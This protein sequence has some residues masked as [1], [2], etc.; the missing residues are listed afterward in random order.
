MKDTG[1]KDIKSLIPHREPFLFVDE[2][3]EVMQ[4]YIVGRR[5]YT[6]DDYFFKGHF[7]QYPIVPGVIL[8]ESMAQ[9]GGAGVVA[10]G[11]GKGLIP[12]FATLDKV[13]FR[14]PVLP[15]DDVR[16]EIENIRMSEKIVR[17]AGKAYVEDDL[18][19]E[20]TWLCIL[21]NKEDLQKWSPSP[22]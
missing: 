20:A 5:R 4:E 16:F 10:L 3:L 11:V 12:F 8:T 22:K 2:L 7:P 21:N 18:A 9:C 6:M 13:K 17:Q 19:A 1:I 14:R 15:G